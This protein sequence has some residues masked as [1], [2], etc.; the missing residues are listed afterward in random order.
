MATVTMPVEQWER[1]RDAAKKHEPWCAHHWKAACDDLQPGDLDPIAPD[2]EPSVEAMLEEL[3]AMECR[4]KIEWIF[5]KTG[6]KGYWWCSVWRPSRN[7]A[8]AEVDVGKRGKTPVAALRA[9]YAQVVG[10]DG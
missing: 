8:E 4:P 7:G 2:T 5:F 3:A 6:Y 9:A 10:E 1:V